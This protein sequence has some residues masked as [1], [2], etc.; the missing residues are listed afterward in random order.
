MAELIVRGSEYSSFLNCRKQWFYQWYEGIEAKRPDAKLF[1]GTAFHKWLENYYN[2]GCNKLLAD[3]ETST[4]INEQD[5][6]DMDQIAIDDMMSLMRGV[7][8]HYHNTYGETDKNFKVIET[9]MEFL[10]KLDEDLFMTGTIDLVYEV[11]GKIRFMD[12]K[13]VSS[14]SMYEE[15]AVMDR[16][17]SRYWW[18]L[19]MIAAGIGRV[20]EKGTGLWKKHPDLLDKTIDGFDYNLIAKDFPKEPKVL[21]SGKLSTDKSQK[22][23]FNK[24]LAKLYELQLNSDEYQEILNY[25]RTKPNQF[26]SRVDVKRSDAELESAAWEFS[27]TSGN[28]H[29]VKMMIT[30]NPQS[31]EP[32]TYRNITNNCMHMCQ[33]K[34]LCQTAIDGGNVN[35]VKN[36][37]YKKREKM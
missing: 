36:L 8:E 13:T 15:K 6:K 28:I 37:G 3:L 32:L 30:E 26:H 5:T 9:E 11:D 24:Y 27:Y 18:A 2:S 12:H 22:T 7:A 31:I 19:K 23:T 16:Q 17:I 1:F 29:D 21:K 10:V 34:S 25:L 35:M 20:K 14:I 4:W 33:F